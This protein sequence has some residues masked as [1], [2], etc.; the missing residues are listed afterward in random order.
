[1]VGHG[2][3]GGGGG[4]RLCVFVILSLWSSLVVIVLVFVMV[5]TVLRML[6]AT[7]RTRSWTDAWDAP[8]SAIQGLALLG[9][10]LS[11]V[12]RL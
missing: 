2:R 7:V 3:C 12:P 5:A 10:S 1:M 6:D 9:L 8:C 4:G 11:D